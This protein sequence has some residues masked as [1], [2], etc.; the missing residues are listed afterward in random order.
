M[1]TFKNSQFHNFK[2]ILPHINGYNV[3]DVLKTIV[4]YII[5]NSNFKN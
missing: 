1:Y 3:H 4:V 5:L 2:N